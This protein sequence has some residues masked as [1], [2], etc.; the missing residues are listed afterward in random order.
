M[1]RKF[2]AML[3]ALMTCACTDQVPQLV[4]SPQAVPDFPPAPV[5]MTRSVGPQMLPWLE[6]LRAGTQPCPGPTSSASLNSTTPT[7][8]KL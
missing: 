8:P 3:L 1:W 6:C 4:A 2:K 7:A 5:E